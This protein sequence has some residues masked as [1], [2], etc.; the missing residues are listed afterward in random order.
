MAVGHLVVP[1]IIQEEEEKE[2]H[3]HL[4]EDDEH[5]VQD[6]GGLLL[7][8]PEPPR[9]LKTPSEHLKDLL[10]FMAI[11]I[12]LNDPAWSAEYFQLMSTNSTTTG[13]THYTGTSSSTGTSRLSD[14]DLLLLP[15]LPTTDAT[16]FANILAAIMGLEHHGFN[17]PWAR[18]RMTIIRHDAVSW[19]LCRLLAWKDAIQAPI[20]HRTVILE[21]FSPWIIESWNYAASLRNQFDGLSKLRHRIV[22]ASGRVDAV[23][24]VWRD[25][26]RDIVHPVIQNAS[27][28][29]GFSIIKFRLVL[30]TT[31]EGVV[32][33]WKKV[34]QLVQLRTLAYFARSPPD[35]LYPRI[36][37]VLG[38]EWGE[39]DTTRGQLQGK[40]REEKLKAVVTMITTPDKSSERFESLGLSESQCYLADDCVWWLVAPRTAP[41]PPAPPKPSRR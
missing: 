22:V 11:D 8:G 6:L 15:V 34:E 20:D 38:S 21:G 26:R 5:H 31:L 24:D 3:K 1:Q 40:T 36:E 29:L 7:I 32:M 2:E 12:D 25:W 41:P 33:V 14:D 9:A 30:Q 23:Y 16:A 28:Q 10:A 4:Q 18:E 13:A 17:R 27:K 39:K 37:E 19:P 35:Y